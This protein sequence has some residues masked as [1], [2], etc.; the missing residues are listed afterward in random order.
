MFHSFEI[1]MEFFEFPTF[2]FDHS[3]F[4]FNIKFS[5]SVLI[6][7]FSIFYGD[8]FIIINLFKIKKNKIFINIF[9][10]SKL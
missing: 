10:I 4:F 9:I 3:L 8:F 6:I 1:F 5:F 7:K 2:H